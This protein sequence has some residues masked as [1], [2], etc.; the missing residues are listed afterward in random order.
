MAVAG[1][2]TRASDSL[3]D[4]TAGRAL[5]AEAEPGEE[6]RGL[7]CFLELPARVFQLGSYPIDLLLRLPLSLKGFE[8][9]SSLLNQRLLLGDAL[10]ILSEESLALAQ[11]ELQL[12]GPSLGLGEA[13]DKGNVNLSRRP[14]QSCARALQDIVLRTVP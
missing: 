14:F 8:L 5:L 6:A 12:D 11:L 3:V 7:L 13:V 2:E 1:S 10:S 4:L 9:G